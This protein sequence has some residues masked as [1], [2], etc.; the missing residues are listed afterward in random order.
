MPTIPA[1]ARARRHLDARGRGDVTLVATGGLRTAPD[2]AKA[3]ALGADAVAVAN[4]AIQ[5]VGCVGMRAC[6]TN[7]C[8]VGVATQDEHLRERLPVDEAADRLAR[9]LTA[10]TQLMT[11]VARAC[12]HRHLS[13][14]ALED[15][16]TYDR[17]LHFLSG[18]DYAG[19]LGL[20]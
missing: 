7:K 20:T 19:V 8:P 4:S 5:A 12:G 10:S 13:E 3:L 1:L 14:F 2:F 17:D 16:V 11:V 18:V 15:L 9:F 6:H